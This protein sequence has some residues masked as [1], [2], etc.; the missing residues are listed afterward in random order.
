MLLIDPYRYPEDVFTRTASARLTPEDLQ[1]AAY[2]VINRHKEVYETN[3]TDDAKEREVINNIAIVLSKTYAEL[4]DKFQL[5]DDQ[6]LIIIK[7][8]LLD[9]NLAIIARNKNKRINKALIQKINS[10]GF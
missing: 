7:D 9:Y 8:L 2:R 5:S 6:A 1:Q 4:G 3:H 10:P